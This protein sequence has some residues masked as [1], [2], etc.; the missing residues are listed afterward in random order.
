[1]S[2][3]PNI[4]RISPL[5]PRA[6]RPVPIIGIDEAAQTVVL[7]AVATAAAR[8]TAADLRAAAHHV[9][10]LHALH[11]AAHAARDAGDFVAYHERVLRDFP[12]L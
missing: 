5:G 3:N 4:I 1:M 2:I 12:A 9:A 7:V 11:V 10:D 6:I 8:A